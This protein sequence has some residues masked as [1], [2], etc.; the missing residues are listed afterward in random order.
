MNDELQTDIRILI[1]TLLN[2]PAG[3]VRPGNQNQPNEG[4]EYVI[5]RLSEMSPT[6]WGGGGKDAYQSGIATFT[7]DFMGNNASFNARNLAIAMKSFYASSALESMNLGFIHCS[8]ARDLSMIEMDMTPRYQVK[9]QFSY[10]FKYEFP[11]LVDDAWG[12]VESI[13]IN[14][15]AEQ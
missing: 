15:I 1:R 4:D 10:S 5:V 7:L 11:Q 6:G 13:K 12:Q 14:L 8:A 2:M 3:S 9:L